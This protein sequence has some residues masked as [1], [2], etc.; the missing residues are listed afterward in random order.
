MTSQRRRVRP[1]LRTRL[2]PALPLRRATLAWVTSALSAVLAF[3]SPSPARS[4]ANVPTHF[5]DQLVMG[6]LKSPV[7]MTFLP[8]GRLVVVEQAGGVRMIVEGKLAGIDPIGAVDSVLMAGEQGLTG[9]VADYRW[10]ASPYIYVYYDA[11]GD[12]IR[13]SRYRAVGD[14]NNPTSGNLSLDPA[15]RFD[16]LRDIPDLTYTHNGGTV[17][18]GNDH[19]LY[20]GLGED[21]YAC[22]SQDTTSLRGVMLRLLVDNLPD[23]PG[24]A[25]KAL[26]V[27]PDNPWA[28]ASN[29]NQR[30]VYATG[31]RNPFRFHVDPLNGNLFVSDVGWN[32]FEEID[33]IDG[34]LI[35]FGWPYLEGTAPYVSS[36]PGIAAGGTLRSPIYEYDRSGFTASAIGGGVYRPSG[37]PT[38]SFP[39]EY[40]GD[41][42]FSDFYEGFLRRLHDYG[43]GVWDV[44]P[45][46]PGQPN[47]TNW[48]TGFRQVSE[49]LVGPDGALWYCKMAHSF[50]EADSVT[51]E[52]RRIYYE[53]EITAVNEGPM[54]GLELMAPFPSPSRGSSQI[55][56]RLPRPSM[57]ELSIFDPQGRRVRS[58]V[59][60]SMQLA[61]EH[62][63]GW[64]GRF[65]SGA[66]APTGMY[67]IRMSANGVVRER[68][69]P[70]V[71]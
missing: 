48:A 39:V 30:L 69:L 16:V 43:G 9:V 71:R 56:F 7:G 2:R 66:A 44:A 11:L 25:D 65:D 62:R 19:M 4:Q 33:V 18:F 22:G 12:H 45:P 36:C 49:Y 51:G 60:G 40:N 37:C 59:H 23:G 13:L 3:A 58:L 24:V 27:P 47:A 31:L 5:V 17:R 67:M 6:N 68:R 20:V 57:V 54:R 63:V 35:N 55:H 34:P 15:S 1:F 41:Y 21:A 53:P 50:D 29:P 32:L 42:F 52:I 46:V 61:G 28:G 14:L 10:P 38:C 26:L 70:L 8:D 64:D